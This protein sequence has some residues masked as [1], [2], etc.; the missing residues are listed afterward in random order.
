MTAPLHVGILLDTADYLGAGPS[1]FT[2]RRGCRCHSLL[3]RPDP[4]L[5][6]GHP[7]F[8]NKER[9]VTASRVRP[10]GSAAGLSGEEVRTMGMRDYLRLNGL[11]LHFG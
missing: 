8:A 4:G 7:T 9:N 5:G 2:L 3:S 1:G 10:V 6:L 11:L